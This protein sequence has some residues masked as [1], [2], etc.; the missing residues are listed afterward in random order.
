[1]IS[2]W[3]KKKKGRAKNDIK[4]INLNYINYCDLKWKINCRFFIFLVNL[5]CFRV[6]L[7]Q[8]F[9]SGKNSFSMYETMKMKE[10]KMY[11][12]KKYKNM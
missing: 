6:T 8:S 5:N 4:K 12:S 1:M 7:V 2:F 10:K 9:Q 3:I 11:I